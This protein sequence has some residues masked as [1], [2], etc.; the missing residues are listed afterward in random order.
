MTRSEALEIIRALRTDF[1]H[2]AGLRKQMADRAKKTLPDS[3]SAFESEAAYLERKVT[4]LSVACDDIC[5]IDQISQGKD[6]A[7][8]PSVFMVDGGEF[9]ALLKAA[10]GVAD[11]EAF[12]TEGGDKLS[13]ALKPYADTDSGT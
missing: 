4:A 11:N 2:A 10:R 9:R 8:A 1:S 13:A 12:T 5:T 6:T 3:A 7:T